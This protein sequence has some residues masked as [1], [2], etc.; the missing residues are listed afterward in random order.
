MAEFIFHGTMT[1][2]F[3]TSGAGNAMAKLTAD[4]VRFIKL[5]YYHG[6]RQDLLAKHF[7]VSAAHIYRITHGIDWRRV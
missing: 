4:Q 3:K 7:K 5:A 1:G 6:A 2:R